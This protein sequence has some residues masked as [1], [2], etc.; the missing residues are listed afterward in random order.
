MSGMQWSQVKS[1]W[2]R[3]R[4]NSDLD[5]SK[6][7]PE[8]C[9]ACDDIDPTDPHLLEYSGETNNFPISN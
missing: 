9:D 5:R 6:S 4:H 2:T 1:D 3:N 8:L 7:Q